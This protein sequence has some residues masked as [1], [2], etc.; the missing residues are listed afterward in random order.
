MPDGKQTGNDAV[1]DETVSLNQ[2]ILANIQPNEI[3]LNGWNITLDDSQ[4][5]L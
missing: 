2:L 4:Q 5:P 1:D 3:E